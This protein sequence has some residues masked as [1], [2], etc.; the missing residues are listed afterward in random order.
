MNFWQPLFILSIAAA[1]SL[2]LNFTSSSA[3]TIDSPQDAETRTRVD[4]SLELIGSSNYTNP[5]AHNKRQSHLA[6][7]LKKKP[8]RDSKLYMDEYDRDHYLDSH[9]RTSVTSIKS[10]QDSNRGS[11]STPEIYRSN[12]QS[13]YNGAGY[14]PSFYSP[15]GSFPGT[16]FGPGAAGS[17]SPGAV[18]FGH[19]PGNFGLGGGLAGGAGHAV[20]HSFHVFDP[21]FIM[22]TLSFLLFLV[23]SILGIVDRLKVP[24]VFARSGDVPLQSD[25]GLEIVDGLIYEIRN[26]LDRYV[27]S[28]QRNGGFK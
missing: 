1:I 2:M 27:A 13:T 5:R 10:D 15:G 6:R 11:S 23:N 12:Y 28:E 19:G 16:G 24:V 17:A 8:L 7:V 26:S 3:S 22:V 20:G 14:G 4:T 9:D 25:L 21:I 18:G